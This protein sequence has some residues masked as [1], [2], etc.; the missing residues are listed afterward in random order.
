MRRHKA[1]SIDIGRSRHAHANPCVIGIGEARHLSRWK[2]NLEVSH[3]PRVRIL[4][5]SASLYIYF[6][7]F[8]GSPP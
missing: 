4:A 2:G 8:A 6:L 5:G 1:R 3:T 7:F